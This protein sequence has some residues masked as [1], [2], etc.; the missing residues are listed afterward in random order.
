MATIWYAEKEGKLIFHSSL[1][2]RHGAA[3]NADENVAVAI[4]S[5]RRV[6]RLRG[7]QMTGKVRRDDSSEVRRAYLRRFPIARF[8]KLTL[9]V[10]EPNYIKFTNNKLGLFFD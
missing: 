2:T 10:L 5:G 1:D 6:S 8:M 4:N 3:M 9:W 7:V